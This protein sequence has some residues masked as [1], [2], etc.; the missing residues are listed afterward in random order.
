MREGERR[1]A[2]PGPWGPALR[3]GGQGLWRAAAGLS[4]S[5]R[6]RCFRREQAISR[7]R[8]ALVGHRGAAAG[9]ERLLPLGTLSRG[10]VPLSPGVGEGGL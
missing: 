9:D 3:S 1:L 4:H 8:G 10:K 7:P 5:P 6:R 2:G